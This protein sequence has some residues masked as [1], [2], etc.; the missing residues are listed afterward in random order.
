MVG[1]IK[2]L[3]GGMVSRKVDLGEKT[4]LTRLVFANAAGFLRIRDFRRRI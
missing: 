4:I 2:K 3:G 1:K